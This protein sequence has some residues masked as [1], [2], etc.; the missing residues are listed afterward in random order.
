MTH[1]NPTRRGLLKGIAAGGVSLTFAGYAGA[2][3]AD[4]YIVTVRGAGA[5]RSLER[6]GFTIRRSLAG[7]DQV[8]A[9][10]I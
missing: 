10:D 6:A 1:S 3:D 2:D 8:T 4:R 7:G 5:D 9:D